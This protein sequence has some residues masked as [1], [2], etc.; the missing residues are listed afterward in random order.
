MAIFL[1]IAWFLGPGVL[2]LILDLTQDGHGAYTLVIYAL[3][4]AGWF[5]Y[6]E[7]KGGGPRKK[8]IREGEDG[9]NIDDVINEYGEFKMWDED[10]R[11]KDKDDKKK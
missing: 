8:D 2:G 6:W 5:I 7:C 9:K 3:W 4:L 1:I 10:L 11:S